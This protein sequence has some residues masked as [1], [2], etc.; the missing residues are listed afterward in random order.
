MQK[1]LW[2]PGQGGLTSELAFISPQFKGDH[3]LSPAQS[4]PHVVLS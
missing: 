1:D 3:G 2:S 4:C